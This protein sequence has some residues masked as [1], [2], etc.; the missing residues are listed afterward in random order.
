MRLTLTG[1]NMN[2]VVVLFILCLWSLNPVLQ[3][4]PGPL[5]KAR[6]DPDYQDTTIPPNIAPLNF[7][8]KEPGNQF[9]VRFSGAAGKP[10]E[11]VSR[12]PLIQIPRQPWRELLQ[13]NRGQ[14][15]I[16][17]IAVRNA[18][19]QW[20]AFESITNQIAKEV[21]DSHLVYRFLNWQYS[22]FGSG[23]MGIYQR[24]LESFE[25]RTVL[26]IKE[27][28]T[29]EATCMNCH[30]FI[31]NRPDTMALQIRSSSK[32]KPMLLAHGG[33]VTT[34]DRP[35]G[36][37]AWHPSGRFL[38]FSQNKFSMLF[39]SVG[40][41]EDVF[42]S[43]G[44]LK[45]YFLE[46]NTMLDCEPVADPDLS[47]TWP[48]WAPDGRH[49]YFCRSPLLPTSRFREVKYDLMR[50]SFDPE[51]LKWGE[52]ETVL[53][54]KETGLS[55]NQPKVSPDGR[56]LLLSLCPY[57]GFPGTQP[58][59]DLYLMDLKSRKYRRLDEVNS[60][61]ADSYHCWSSNSRWFVFSSKRR[62]GALTRPYLGYLDEN[63]QA[64]KPFLVPQKDPMF[65]DTTL[66][67]IN[68]PELVNG[69]I[70]VSQHALYNSIFSPTRV[71]KPG[72][73]GPSAKSKLR[74]NAAQEEAPEQNPYHSPRRQD[75][76]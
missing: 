39:H 8:I 15:M 75:P 66:K 12:E 68:V 50:I 24:D 44:D 19:D 61:R 56:F 52:V 14:S 9:R 70:T 18:Q 17:E 51:T 58:G 41:N 73:D 7:R 74:P 29:G 43:G 5:P 60:D 45:T 63:G 76:H 27:Y 35:S 26:R 11:V 72:G 25:V 59:S 49:L 33:E 64:R 34:V 65:Y 40:R 71:V 1:K 23:N 22:M 36:F 47:E 53:T 28:T 4:A 69:P 32:G 21:V 38:T 37:V 54:A 57:S 42:D 62:D 6:M 2:T 13:A 3:A 67:M 55:I 46:K 31:L 30:S 48:A 20:Q 10:V 16:M